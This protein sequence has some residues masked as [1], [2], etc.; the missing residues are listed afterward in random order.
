MWLVTV[1]LFFCAWLIGK[2]TNKLN[3]SAKTVNRT[4]FF[5]PVLTLSFT[6]TSG[7]G[8]FS[9]VKANKPA[10]EVL[11]HDNMFVNK[12]LVENVYFYECNCG[13]N[14]QKFYLIF[15]NMYVKIH[16]LFVCLR[17]EMGF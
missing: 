5:R 13:I 16:V 15:T 9:F 4:L 2:K 10:S 1:Q 12:A 7:R 17:L 8:V 11:E 6:E 3:S 14:N